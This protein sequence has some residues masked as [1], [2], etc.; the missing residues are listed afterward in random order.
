MLIFLG[1]EVFIV[2]NCIL[3]HSQH[4]QIVLTPYNHKPLYREKIRNKNAKK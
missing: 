1:L 2:D 4:F 3:K